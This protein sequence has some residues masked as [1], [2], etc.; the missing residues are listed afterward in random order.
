MEEESEE[1]N[2]G[3]INDLVRALLGKTKKCSKNLSDR[4][5]INTIFS[6]FDAYIHENFQKFIQMSEQ[7]YKSIKSGNHLEKK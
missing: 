2:Q 4:V 6:E 7:R 1:F 5:K 3:D